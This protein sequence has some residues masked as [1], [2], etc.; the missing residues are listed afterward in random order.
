M[1]NLLK[2]VIGS[3][4]VLS[5]ALSTR[6]DHGTRPK[7]PVEVS[8]HNSTGEVSIGAACLAG[9]GSCIP[10]LCPAGTSSQ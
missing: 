1:K 4:I 5:A 10:N 7:I 9:S 2:L 3:V 8:C 6:A